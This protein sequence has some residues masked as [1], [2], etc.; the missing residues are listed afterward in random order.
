MPSIVVDAGPLIA[1]FDR[2]EAHHKQALA[3]FES[4]QQPPLTNVVVLAEVMALLPTPFQVDFLD[5]ATGGLDIDRDTAGDMPRIVEIIR[6]YADLPADFADASLLALC[7]RRG[8]TL[9]ATLDKDFDVYRTVDRKRLHNVFF[10][11]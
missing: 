3:Y 1:L 4:L 7:E 2:S 8:L 9:V 10:K 11:R 5:W 6:K